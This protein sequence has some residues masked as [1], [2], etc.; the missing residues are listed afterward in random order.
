LP[1]FISILIASDSFRPVKRCS[2]RLIINYSD[3]LSGQCSS[4][5]CAILNRTQVLLSCML[6]SLGLSSRKSVLFAC[7]HAKKS[8][9]RVLHHIGPLRSYLRPRFSANSRSIRHRISPLQ[10]KQQEPT[11]PQGPAEIHNSEA[12]SPGPEPELN[13]TTIPEDDSK[14][15]PLEFLEELRRTNIELPKPFL[16]S[17]CKS[18]IR[19]GAPRVAIKC[20]CRRYASSELCACHPGTV[21]HQMPT[22]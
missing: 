14:P 6:R 15:I 7:W 22:L 4:G 12:I 1:S 19:P 11:P 8:N 13:R 21:S 18:C 2:K 20:K 16:V 9:A 3:L 17:Y 10:K 5:V